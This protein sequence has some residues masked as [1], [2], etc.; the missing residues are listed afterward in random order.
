MLS[1]QTFSHVIVLHRKIRSTHSTR[2]FLYT[3]KK[4]KF[5]AYIKSISTREGVRKKVNVS[6]KI[7]FLHRFDD[8]YLKW[9]HTHSE[10]PNALD[11][12]NGFTCFV[13]VQHNLKQWLC[14][15]MY[16][17][18][19]SI[20]NCYKTTLFC[21][22]NCAFLKIILN[23]NSIQFCVCV[24]YVR[25]DV[26]VIILSLCSS[27]VW[28]WCLSSNWINPLRWLQCVWENIRDEKPINHLIKH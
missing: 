25:C 5:S 14:C 15:C 19:H 27:V 2:Q 12:D 3:K 10:K 23:D 1:F 21:L 26:I 4:R 22:I 11:L 18:S 13:F 6:Y 20:I 9:C 17:F 16:F 8:I 28:K 24:I 7:Q